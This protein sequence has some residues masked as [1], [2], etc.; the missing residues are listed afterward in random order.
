M[1]KY[2][3]ELRFICES[4]AG[5]QDSVGFN[6]IDSVI[7]KARTKVFDFDYPIFDINYKPVL[8]RKIIEHYYTREICEETVGLW[9]LRL[10]AKMNEIMPYYNKLYESELL[11]FNP[12]YNNDYTKDG[13]RNR[14]DDSTTNTTGV[15]NSVDSG[16]DTGNRV[17]STGGEDVRNTNRE[18]GGSDTTNSAN[19]YSEWDL[20]S[21][22]PQGGI[23]GILGAEDEPSL[24]DNGYLT[25]ARHILHDGTGTTSTT[26]YG[27]TEDTEET[28]EYGR[29]TTE[30][31]TMNYG[32]KNVTDED[33]DK[34][35]DGKSIED[36]VERVTGLIG[37]NP[38]RMVKEF[39]DTFLNI[40]LDIIN[41]LRNLF[42]NLW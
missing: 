30:T 23:E 2:T 22:T 19:K 14:K 16:T 9:K 41:S 42:F 21:D 38:S 17:G 15:R 4:Y 35:F 8:E 32:R 12:L 13:N 24:L 27:G 10:K 7:S 25:N 28:I 1:S 34:V 36:Y 11:E 5:L 29:T 39:R 31:N 37:E 6:D 18:R 26:Q 3:T 40:D 33:Q 20:Y